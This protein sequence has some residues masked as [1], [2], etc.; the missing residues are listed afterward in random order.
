MPIDADLLAILVCPET[1]QPLAMATDKVLAKVNTKVAGKGGLKN[2][3]GDV[4]KG[5]IAE[6][7]LREDG[8]ALYVIEDGIPNLLIDERIDL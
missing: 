3:Q 4:V 1:H 7:L 2:R 5:E 8:K 6:G